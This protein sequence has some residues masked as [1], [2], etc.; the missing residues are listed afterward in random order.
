MPDAPTA[1]EAAIR[2][3]AY[4]LWEREGRPSGRVMEFWSR[5]EVALAG[6]A[7][8]DTLTAA[9]PKRS[10]AGVAAKPKAPKAEK[11]K[12]KKK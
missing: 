1:D 8:V 10:K 12:Q 9:P 11:R 2:E 7:Q 5:A 6:K 3:Q 4:L